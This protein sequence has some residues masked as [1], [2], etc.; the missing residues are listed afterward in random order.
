M[1]HHVSL[2]TYAFDFSHRAQSPPERFRD[3]QWCVRRGQPQRLSQREPFLQWL[4]GRARGEP[5]IDRQARQPRYFSV[6]KV[7]H[8]PIGGQSVATNSR[9]VFEKRKAMKHRIQPI[10]AGLILSGAFF[11]GNHSVRAMALCLCVSL[12]LTFISPQRPQRGTEN[13]KRHQ[14]AKQPNSGSSKKQHA[15]AAAEYP[16]HTSGHQRRQRGCQQSS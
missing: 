10:I 9:V 8:S 12:S 6:K 11:V 5:C 13:F 1:A 14:K 15:F 7:N 3:D 4:S 16:R 2:L